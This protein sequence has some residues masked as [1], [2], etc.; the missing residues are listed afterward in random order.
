[1]RWSATTSSSTPCSQHTSP[2]IFHTPTFLTRHAGLIQQ[3]ALLSNSVALSVLVI[4]TPYFGWLS[5]RMGRKPLLLVCCIG[6]ALLSYPVFRIILNGPW[7]PAIM[8]LQIIM[9][10]FIARRA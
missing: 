3:Q 7:L 9:N 10:L 4:T 2:G 1:M 5:E 6:F 8:A